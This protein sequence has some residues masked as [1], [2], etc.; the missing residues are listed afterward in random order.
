MDLPDNPEE[1]ADNILKYPEIARTFAFESK[2]FTEE[3]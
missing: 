3:F 1:F 2:T